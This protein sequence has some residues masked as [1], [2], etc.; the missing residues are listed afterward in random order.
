L[1]NVLSKPDESEK[2]PTEAEIDEA[3]KESF[4]ASDPPS[5]TLGIEQHDAPQEESD[6][7]GDSDTASAG[8]TS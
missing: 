1:E 2:H 8:R 3:L 5:W 4:P 6:Q 7:E